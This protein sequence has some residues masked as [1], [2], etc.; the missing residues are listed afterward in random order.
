MCAQCRRPVQGRSGKVHFRCDQQTG[1]LCEGRQTAGTQVAA[2]GGLPVIVHVC[3]AGLYADKVLQL[4]IGGE[5]RAAGGEIRCGG[6]R[7]GIVCRAV[8]TAQADDVLLQG[9]VPDGTVMIR[10]RRVEEPHRLCRGVK[11]VERCASRRAVGIV[12][13]DGVHHQTVLVE[14]ESARLRGVAHGGVR[15]PQRMVVH[16]GALH[17]AAAPVAVH[18]GVLYALVVA[19]HTGGERH[20]SGRA[21]LRTVHIH[22]TAVVGR[23]VGEHAAQHLAARVDIDAAAVGFRRAVFEH[24]TALDASAV[25][26]DTATVTLCAVLPDDAV[27][28]HRLC[29]P[30]V[31]AAALQVRA[32]ACARRAALDGDAA[33]YGALREF[34]LI[35]YGSEPH[36]V[37]RFARGIPVVVGPLAR[38]VVIGTL[39]DGLVRVDPGHLAR[40][41]VGARQDVRRIGGETAVDADAV[42]H[43]ERQCGGVVRLELLR[44]TVRA[45]GHPHLAQSA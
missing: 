24:Q 33:Q 4:F 8:R 42:P 1:G 39:Q 26:V 5:C 7:G 3:P 34:R 20:L 35:A 17:H 37:V 43:A 22:G 36:H 28:Q 45:G 29:A 18:G 32:A 30:L 15:G 6:G 2:C 9:V 10:H 25:Q 44:R 19:D 23:V 41:Q 11:R 16:D 13:D 31:D 14:V 40:S 21:V 12:P 27:L 38:A